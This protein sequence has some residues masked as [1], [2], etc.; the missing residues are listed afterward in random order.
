MKRN[1][2]AL[3]IPNHRTLRIDPNATRV[4]LCVELVAL[5]ATLTSDAFARA[6]PCVSCGALEEALGEA[7]CFDEAVLDETAL[8]DGGES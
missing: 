7:F 4:F 8:D 1:I 3:Q 2:N 6:A 5:D